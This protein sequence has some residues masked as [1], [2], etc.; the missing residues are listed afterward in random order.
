[1]QCRVEN[2]N[3]RSCGE[4]EYNILEVHV[5]SLEACSVDLMRKD[6]SVVSKECSSLRLR[7]RKDGIKVM[8]PRHHGFLSARALL[9]QTKS[10][11]IGLLFFTEITDFKD[12]YIEGCKWASL[13]IDYKKGQGI[14]FVEKQYFEK[15][16]KKL[17]MRRDF[18]ETYFFDREMITSTIREKGEII[19]S[20][21]DLIQFQ[22]TVCDRTLQM[23]FHESAV[24]LLDDLAF[25]MALSLL[26]ELK[27]RKRS[28]FYKFINDMMEKNFRRRYSTLEET[29][30]SQMRTY[31]LF[32]TL[33]NLLPNYRSLR[34]E[35]VFLML[36][37]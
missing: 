4:H 1:V 21:E 29:R 24:E 31:L 13:E 33:R 10:E 20:A 8:F 5:C 15:K 3:D 23:Q 25:V 19:N 17:I 14:T 35:D 27:R 18:S 2:S 28:S 37:R 7:D 9:D 11:M 36:K 30:E 16:P 32:E 22:I 12:C 6:F 26:E 34:K